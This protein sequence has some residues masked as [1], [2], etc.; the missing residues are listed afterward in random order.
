MGDLDIR[1]IEDSPPSMRL[2]GRAVRSIL[3]GNDLAP[4]LSVTRWFGSLGYNGWVM[5]ERTRFQLFKT[6]LRP[7]REYG[8]SIMPAAGN[9]KMLE[10]L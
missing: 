9:K 10:K 1:V 2:H 5:H 8:L 7:S 3:E 6:Y 4:L